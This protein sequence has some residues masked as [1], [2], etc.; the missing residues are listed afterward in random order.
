MGRYFWNILIAI[1]Q[2]FNAVLGGY[3]DETISSR[4]GKRV[5]KK[6]CFLCNFICKLL[7]KIDPNHCEKSI[8]WDEGIEKDGFYKG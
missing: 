1:D 6:D 4:M 8:E 7:N 5:A 3:P 2:F